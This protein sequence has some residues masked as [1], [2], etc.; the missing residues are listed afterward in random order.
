MVKRQY[1]HV[2][3][4]LRWLHKRRG[5]E[6]P[7]LADIGWA[8]SVD[9]VIVSILAWGIT[10]LWMWY[11]MKPTRRWGTLCLAVG[12]PPIRRFCGCDMSIT[13]QTEQAANTVPA[14]TGSRLLRFT[15]RLHLY[16]G[17]ALVPWFIMY[18]M[19]AFVLNHTKLVDGWLKS[20]RPEWTMRFERE[21]HCPVPADAEPRAIASRILQDFGLADRSFFAWWENNNR[22]QLTVSAFKFLSRT[23][24]T[25]FADQGRVAAEDGSFRLDRFF[26]GMHERGGF[27]QLPW[28]TKAWGVI[29]DLVGL[30]LLTWVVSGLYV[31]WKT[32]RQHLV[33]GV[34]LAAGVACFIVLV[35]LL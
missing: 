11:K 31:W 17:I 18:A 21:Y 14:K 22:N 32:H 4:F 15:R 5:Y 35:A 6:G 27:A 25:Y 16:L 9:M 7:Y 13:M 30:I 24:L 10:G 29:C 23:R 28:L 2:A 3:D 26:V 1:F 12:V 33:G 8:V 20:D 19:G 34:V